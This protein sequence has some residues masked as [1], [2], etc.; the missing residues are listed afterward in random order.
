[1]SVRVTGES[2]L[3]SNILENERKLEAAASI[4]E[5]KRI[6]YEKAKTLAAKIVSDIMSSN[7]EEKI[8]PRIEIEDEH[9]KDIELPKKKSK[10]E[11]AA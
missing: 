11:A 6:D 1:M 4:S 2:A 8:G 10:Q 7:K 3:K 5:V 9:M